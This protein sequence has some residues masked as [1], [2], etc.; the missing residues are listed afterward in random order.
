[1]A[2]KDLDEVLSPP[3]PFVLPRRGK[4]Y[5]FPGEITA[6]TWL[7]VQR[8]GERAQRAAQAAAAGEDYS[9]DEEIVSDDDQEKLLE[10]LCGET[11]AEILADGFTDRELKVVLTT[12][13]AYHMG[14]LEAAE[15]VWNNQGE[16]P[17]PNRAERRSQAKPPRPASSRAGSNRQKPPEAMAAHGPRS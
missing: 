10:E 9:P 3:E 5:A 16:A 12:L 4:E 6:A 2:F 1:M 14:G 15:A 8:V 7:R 11:L 17:A 13:I